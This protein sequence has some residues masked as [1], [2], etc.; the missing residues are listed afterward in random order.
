MRIGQQDLIDLM[1]QDGSSLEEAKEGIQNLLD[2][3]A[4]YLDGNKKI[5]LTKKWAKILKRA[6]KKFL[7]KQHGLTTPDNSKVSP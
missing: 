3:K 5:H 2:A 7:Q 6:T 4:I 1:I